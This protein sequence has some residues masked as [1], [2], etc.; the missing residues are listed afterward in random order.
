MG[1]HESYC[2]VSLSLRGEL[3]DCSVDNQYSFVAEY[4]TKYY[5][6]SCKEDLD[7]F[8]SNPD[9]FVSPDCKAILPPVEKRPKLLTEV[10]K[11]V[12]PKEMELQGFCPVTYI[13]GGCL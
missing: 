10:D 3:V 6:F 5:R 12:F 13:N 11:S 9:Q 8:L 1:E 2:P 4:K 7:A